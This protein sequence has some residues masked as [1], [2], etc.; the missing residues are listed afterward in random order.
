[1]AVTILKKTAKGKVKKLVLRP[2]IAPRWIDK[3]GLHVGKVLLAA[4][5]DNRGVIIRSCSPLLDEVVVQDIDTQ[6]K[7]GLRTMSAHQCAEVEF[8]PIDPPFEGWVLRVI[9]G[10]AA[11]KARS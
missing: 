7:Y 8:Y 11:A 10:R 1:M 3:C 4:N 6:G 9:E 5:G 2:K